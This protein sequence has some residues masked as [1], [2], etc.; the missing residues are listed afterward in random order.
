M[1]KRRL[2]ALTVAA[3]ALA[4]PAFAELPPAAYERARAEATDV[5]VLDVSRVQMLAPGVLEGACEVEGRIASVDKGDLTAGQT[6]TLQAPCIDVDW[7]PRPGP[8][9]G[10]PETALARALQVKVWLKDDQPVLR[11]LDVT[12]ERP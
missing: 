9:P 12:A 1:L 3:G 11:G 6:L 7:T 2:I 4:G 5:V 10:Y 8:F